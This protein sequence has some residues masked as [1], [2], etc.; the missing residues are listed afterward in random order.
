MTRVIPSASGLISN[1]SVLTLGVRRR[2][3]TTTRRRPG[4]QGAAARRG[5][6]G[7]PRRS[8]SV[9]TKQGRRRPGRRP[10]RRRGAGTSPP[11]DRT[12]RVC[13]ST[14]ASQALD[15]CGEARRAGRTSPPWRRRG[16]GC[17]SVVTSC[18]TADGGAVPAAAGCGGALA[19]WVAV[20]RHSPEFE[21]VQ[22]PKGGYGT[23]GSPTSRLGT[24]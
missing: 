11:E 13:P 5:R 24:I 23:V 15:V 21:T 22:A 3:Q 4:R 7:A 10:R 8:A 16:W 1:D 6:R 14:L 20:G 17:R 9:Q 18:R 19:R 12:G 2:D